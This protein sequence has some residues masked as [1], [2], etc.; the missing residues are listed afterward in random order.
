MAVVGANGSGKSTL[1]RLCNGLLVPTEGQVL[2][3]GRPTSNEDA[4]WEA[5]RRVGVVFQNP[6]NQLVAPTVEEEVAFGPENLGVAPQEIG[7][8]V[9]RSLALVGLQDKRKHPPHLLSGGQKQLVAIAAVMAMHPDVLIL[10]EATA[11]LDP[12]SRAQVVETVSRLC[13]TELVAVLLITH[14]MDEVVDAHRV[15]AL[16]EGRVVFDGPP[17]DLLDDE[18]LLIELGMDV[19]PVVR[20]ARQLAAGGAPVLRTTYRLDELVDQLCR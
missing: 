14:H 18:Q 11:M 15:I 16:A 7:E 1:A 8:R 13:R 6:D 2:I 17:H 4:L 5:R 12:L 20:M 9:E 10:D 3:G 19:P